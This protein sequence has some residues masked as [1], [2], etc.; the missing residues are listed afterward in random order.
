[1]RGTVLFRELCS[2]SETIRGEVYQHAYKQSAKQLS[3]T[4]W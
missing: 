1:M 2:L 4:I 3:E